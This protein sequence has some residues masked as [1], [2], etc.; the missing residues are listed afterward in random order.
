MWCPEDYY[1]WDSV[2]EFWI[3]T[4]GEI[5]SLVALG[6]EAPAND[7]EEFQP[8]PT[9]EFYL[10]RSRIVD[11]HREAEMIVAITACYLMCKF[12]EEYPPVLASLDGNKIIADNVFFEHKDQLALC[13]YKWPPN[14]DIQFSGFF[15]YQ[16]NG[17]F[18]PK[19]IYQRF[20]FIDPKSGEFRLK[21]GARHFL[22]N[23]ACCGAEETEKLLE[24]ASKLRGRVVCWS[25][26]PDEEELRNFLSHLEVDDTFAMAL[27]RAFGIAIEDNPPEEKRPVGRPDKKQAA[28]RE[29][30]RC[31]PQGHKK[32]G[33]TWK[34]VLRTVNMTLDEPVE[35]T[36]LKRALRMGGKNSKNNF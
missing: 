35:I 3:A 11:S 33:K 22:F 24:T 1:S 31:F 2:L 6:G 26:F 17:I 15:K 4:S 5:L 12:L 13:Q 14:Q 32:S 10:K 20:A 34:E 27:D 18:E 23:V 21:N 8:R 36:T 19:D 25:N 9:A 29:Y 30:W 7:I 28:S 16:R